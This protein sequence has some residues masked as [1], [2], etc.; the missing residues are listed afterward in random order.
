MTH[1]GTVR[2]VNEDACYANPEIGVWAV[3]DGLG[4][5]TAGDF[6]SQTIV[7]ELQRVTPSTSLS[8][9]V[10]AVE[11]QILRADQRIADRSAATPG[12]PMIGSTVAALLGCNSQCALLWAGDSRVYRLRGSDFRAMTRDHSEVEEMVACGELTREQARDHPLANVISRA[13]G[14]LDV[15]RS[16]EVRMGELRA[17]DRYL[18]CTDGLYRVLDDAN[19]AHLLSLGSPADVCDNLLTHALTRPCPDNLTAVVV[20]FAEEAP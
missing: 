20:T 2:R 1:V 10:D 16:V 15:D 4:G 3:A 7:Q 17:G 18:L 12:R 5:H 19:L 11:Q 8:E 6:A 13:V 9:F 14:V